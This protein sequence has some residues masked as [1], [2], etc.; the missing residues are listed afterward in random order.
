M[1][2]RLTFRK[3]ASMPKDN[4]TIAAKTLTDPRLLMA[5]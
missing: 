4:A 1:G 2:L 3:V 5:L